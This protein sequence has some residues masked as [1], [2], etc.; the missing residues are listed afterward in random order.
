[1]LPP[2]RQVPGTVKR[3]FTGGKEIPNYEYNEGPAFEESAL[4]Q[5]Q[6]CTGPIQVKVKARPML[7]SSVI[8][9]G[10]GPS[11]STE[12]ATSH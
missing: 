9:T 4:F 1:M 10:A 5:G 6:I 2:T 12:K 7:V 11:G 8:L 3:D